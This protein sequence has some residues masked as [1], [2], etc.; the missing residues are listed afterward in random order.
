[1][2]RRHAG[3]VLITGPIQLGSKVPPWWALLSRFRIA[4]Q[5]EGE[6]ACVNT[7]VGDGRIYTCTG[8]IYTYL[9]RGLQTCIQTC[10]YTYI[11]MLTQGPQRAPA[12]EPS[13]TF[14]LLGLY[15]RND[16]HCIK[17]R[18]SCIKLRLYQ[19][20]FKLRSSRIVKLHSSCI[21]VASS[22][23]QVAFKCSSCVHHYCHYER[24]YCHCY[25]N[26]H[27]HYERNDCHCIKSIPV[28]G[29]KFAASGR[30]L[31]CIKLHQV[32]SSWVQV[33][34]RCPG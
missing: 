24:N 17:L 9:H 2:C 33:A 7:S 32:A 19:V 10:I 29:E 8:G 18:S 16:C 30:L 1:M 25:Y 31:L 13:H 22:W 3:P 26:H 6:C 5:G 20:V 4:Q 28:A 21:Q 11:H 27:I 15:E 23:V 12:G 34:F 14:G